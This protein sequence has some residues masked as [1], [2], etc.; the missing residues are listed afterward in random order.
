MFEN[1]KSIMNSKST[2]ESNSSIFQSVL[3]K[4]EEHKL[5]LKAGAKDF[6]DDDSWKDEMLGSQYCL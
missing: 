1:N 3:D 4:N 6:L 5:K 2:F